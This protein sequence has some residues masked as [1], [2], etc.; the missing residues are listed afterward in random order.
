M[1][2]ELKTGRG[3][4]TTLDRS[5]LALGVG[6]LSGGMFALMLALGGGVRSPIGLAT[7]LAG[8][9]FVSMVL[10]VAAA[11][12][13]WLLCHALRW[14]G[15][16]AAAVVGS[17]VGFVL[18]LAGQTYGFG[19]YAM[20]ATDPRTLLFRWLSGVATSVPMAL[21]AA[22]IGLAIWRVAYRRV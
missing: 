22:G 14:R 21:V 13:L 3:Y 16:A 17:L 5:G 15:P 10:I 1:V 12:P 18:F 20:P 4:R 19:L 11:G 9:T 2:L 8:G 6:G 7:M